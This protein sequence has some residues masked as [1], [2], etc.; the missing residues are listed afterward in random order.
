MDT[1][2]YPIEPLAP[3]VPTLPTEANSIA[4]FY[5]VAVRFTA[6][7][8][9]TWIRFVRNIENPSLNPSNFIVRSSMRFIRVN[10]ACVS[11]QQDQMMHMMTGGAVGASNIFDPIT[12][13][14]VDLMD[15]RAEMDRK[16]LNN[17]YTF[18]K[19]G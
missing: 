8:S 14:L 4:D 2:V 6:E 15:A 11:T 12:Y 7:G 10:D 18:Q 19:L 5:L 16:D 13:Q 1:S 17:E 3:V 9:R